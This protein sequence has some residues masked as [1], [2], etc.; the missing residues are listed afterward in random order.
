MIAGQLGLTA[1]AERAMLVF[2]QTVRAFR[3]ATITYRTELPAARVVRSIT[4][5]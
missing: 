5:F 3:V 2:Q 4:N 1:S